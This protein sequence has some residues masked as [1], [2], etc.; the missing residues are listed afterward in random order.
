MFGCMKKTVHI[1][2]R[3]LAE[4]KTACQARTDTDTIR[5]GLEAL[6]RQAAQQRLR[7]LLGTE[8]RPADVP[9]H[10]EPPRTRR[11]AKKRVA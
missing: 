5:L 10:R 1:Q 9:R 4:A 8:P 7:A 3:L 2:D 11:A 6:V